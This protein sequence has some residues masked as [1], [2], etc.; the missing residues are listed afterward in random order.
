MEILSPGTFEI[1]I[2]KKAYAFCSDSTVFRQNVVVRQTLD[3]QD[4]DGV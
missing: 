4:A 2:P 1:I 3:L